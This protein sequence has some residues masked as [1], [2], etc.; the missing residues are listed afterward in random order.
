MRWG[1][2]KCGKEGEVWEGGREG[3]RVECGRGEGKDVKN[4]VNVCDWMCSWTRCRD[5]VVCMSGI[6]NVY[7]YG[8]I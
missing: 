4:M 3:G 2:G 1:E 5:R 7:V 8:C 6:V